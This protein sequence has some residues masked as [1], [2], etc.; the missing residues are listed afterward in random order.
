MFMSDPESASGGFTVSFSRHVN[1]FQQ[2]PWGWVGEW[3]G[4]C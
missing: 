2:W 3:V 4:G 1:P